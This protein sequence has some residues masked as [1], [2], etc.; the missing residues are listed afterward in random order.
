MPKTET[1]GKGSKL[2]AGRV[3]TAVVK[4]KAGTYYPGMPLSY[5]ATDKAYQYQADLTDA[6][7][8]YYGSRRDG[9]EAGI[10]YGQVIIGGQIYESG[11]VDNNNNVIKL[12]DTHR[13]FLDFKGFCLK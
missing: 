11:I 2:C 10:E 9:T 5:N 4:L 3:Y 8:F 1:L 13:K 7:A 6:V 12:T